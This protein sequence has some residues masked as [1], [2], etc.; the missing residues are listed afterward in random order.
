[1]MLAPVLSLKNRPGLVLL[2]FSAIWPSAIAVVGRLSTVLL[3][4]L[5]CVD[6]IPLTP[7]GRDYST[8]LVFAVV[9][10]YVVSFK[11][12]GEVAP[13]S[14][15]VGALDFEED[16]TGLAADWDVLGAIDKSFSAV[17]H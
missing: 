13:C 7:G 12:V 8:S 10:Y 6:A 16:I 9:E 15:V 11:D 5:L 4:R 17:C 2:V 14:V 3:R 1:M